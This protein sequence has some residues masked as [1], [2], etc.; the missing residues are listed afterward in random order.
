MPAAVQVIGSLPDA[1]QACFR[2]RASPPRPTVRWD[3]TPPGSSFLD[4]S[5]LQSS[6]APLSGPVPFGP[7]LAARVPG[8]PTTSPERVHSR[9]AFQASLR[10]V[11]GL[12]R[13]LDGLLRPPARGLVSSPSHVQDHSC[14]GA[15]TSAQPLSLVGRRC[16]L[17]VVHRSARRARRPGGHAAETRLRGLAPRGDAWHRRGDWPQRCSLPS[18]GSALLQVLPSLAVS[19][20]YAGPSTH[21]VARRSPACAVALRVAS[22]VLSARDP[23][24]SREIADLPEILGLLRGFARARRPILPEAPRGVPSG[25]IDSLSF[26]RSARPTARPPG[27]PL[28]Q[29]LKEH[30]WFSSIF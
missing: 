24:I 21:G 26:P 29:S 5:P 17:A 8:P 12:P 13:P 11:L 30:F 27:S 2:A 9:E 10:S 18:S 23:T 16:P 7:G 19:P 4:R 6:F 3:R 20:A 25:S 1:P 14:P 22:S 15:S 28:T